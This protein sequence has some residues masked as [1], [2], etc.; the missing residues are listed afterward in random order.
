MRILLL[1]WLGTVTLFGYSYD[2]L[3]LE[4]E[5]SVFPKLL[6]LSKH[7][8]TLTVEGKLR[9]FILYEEED[10]PAAEHLRQEMLQHYRRDESP[11]ALDVRL[12]AFEAVDHIERASALMALYSSER[13]PDVVRRAKKLHIPS[14]VFDTAYLGEGFLFSLSIEH[15]VTVYLNASQLPGYG[16]AFSDALYQI[17][18]LYDAGQTS[19]VAF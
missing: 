16:I 13:Y 18:R 2:R 11:Y 19:S 4:A 10:W 15:A 9:F 7:P 5:A 1:L 3:L 14:F 8:E 17:V 12:L 6:L